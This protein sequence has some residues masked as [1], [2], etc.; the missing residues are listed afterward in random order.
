MATLTQAKASLLSAQAKYDKVVQGASN[1]DIALTQVLLKNAQTD[2]ENTKSNQRSLVASAHRAVLNS[3]PEAVSG[4]STTSST[5]PTI[6]G[7]YVADRE[8]TIA[9]TL[10]QASSGWYFNTTGLVISSGLISST[11]PQALGDSGLSIQFPAS[12]SYPTS[13]TITLPNKQ[14]SNYL[15][16]YNAY[17]GAL[18][19]QTSAVSGAQSVVDQRQ[20]ELDLKKAAARTADVDIAQAEVLSAQ[21]SLQSAQAVYEDTVIRAPASS[22][23]TRFDTKYGE[24]ADAG[25][26]VVTLE[27]VKNLYIEALINEAN[28]AYLKMGQVVSITF[29]AFGTE[30]K[31][32]G[33]IVAINPSADTNSGVVNYKIKV[34]IDG[35]DD[36]I[37][38]GMNANITVLAGEV[39]QVLAIPRSSI[40]KKDGKSFVRVFTDEKNKRSAGREIQTG[41]VGDNNLVE[42]TTGLSVGE[43]VVLIQ[44]K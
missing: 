43:K 28:I 18:E 14:A 3:Y 35:T 24:L 11:T 22:T 15:A 42:I 38:P 26:T 19:T 34:S 17:Q 40:T 30:K 12:S 7:T 44:D 2:L 23:I 33:A 29:D 16:N 1:E 41:F 20:A 4:T 9:M 27:D 8:G 37:R 25:K 39:R 5:A 6:T 21:G 10:Y 31:Y 32:T 13:W 36:T